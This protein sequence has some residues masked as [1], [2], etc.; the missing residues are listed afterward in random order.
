MERQWRVWASRRC[1]PKYWRWPCPHGTRP[2]CSLSVA[3]FLTPSSSRKRFKFSKALYM[4]KNSLFSSYYSSLPKISHH[5]VNLVITALSQAC[6]FR[7]ISESLV[8]EKHRMCPGNSF[9]KIR[10]KFTTSYLKL[11]HH[12]ML[13]WVYNDEIQY[14]NSS[15]VR[16]GDI[17]DHCYSQ[18]SS[19]LHVWA[20]RTKDSEH[21]LQSVTA[22]HAAPLTDEMYFYNNNA[23]KI[24]ITYWMQTELMPKK[25]STVL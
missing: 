5:D 21:I 24:D 3:M 15:K 12:R 7:N 11:I 19:D 9:L 1:K 4:G 8:M 22:S 23:N 13:I 25:S 10:W 17:A 20:H 18:M 16:Y 2:P 6:T 14:F